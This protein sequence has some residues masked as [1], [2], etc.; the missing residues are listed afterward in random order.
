MTSQTKLAPS[1]YRGGAFSS[2]Y[3]I[4]YSSSVNLHNFLNI[5]TVRDETFEWTGFFLQ[6]F[7][8]IKSLLPKEYL[9]ICY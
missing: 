9:D 4:F 6:K 5:T 3:G 1:V 2:K 7:Y 8:E